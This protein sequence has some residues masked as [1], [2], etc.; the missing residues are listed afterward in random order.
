MN[1]A[2]DIADAINL[3]VE[4]G[5]YAELPN[6]KLPHPGLAALV[7]T[8]SLFWQALGKALGWRR[9]PALTTIDRTNTCNIVRSQPGAEEWQGHAARYVRVTMNGEDERAFWT[10]LLEKGQQ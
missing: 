4:N 6:G 9:H 3:A 8:D 10:E 2:I 7:A 5:G 1:E